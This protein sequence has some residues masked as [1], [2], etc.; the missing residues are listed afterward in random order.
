MYCPSPK[1]FLP[2]N[3]ITNIPII[4]VRI[5]I[6]LLLEKKILSKSQLTGFKMTKN[7]YVY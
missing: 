6:S 1:Q 3:K 7:H 2:V 5:F 4:S